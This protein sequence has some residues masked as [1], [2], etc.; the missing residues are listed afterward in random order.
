MF[1]V[2]FVAIKG[3][4]EIKEI[5][6]ENRK[7]CFCEVVLLIEKVIMGRLTQFIIKVLCIMACSVRSVWLAAAHSK[8]GLP[9]EWVADWP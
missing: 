6:G 5:A 1:E 9:S 8:V 4:E 2:Y 3:A 7:K